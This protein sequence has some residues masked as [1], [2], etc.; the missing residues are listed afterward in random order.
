MKVSE[1]T[2]EMDF[3][4]LA[5]FVSDMAELP[6]DGKFD[7]IENVDVDKNDKKVYI[8]VRRAHDFD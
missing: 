4:E 7:H 1:L 5:Q 2:L 6:H 8:T 3:Y